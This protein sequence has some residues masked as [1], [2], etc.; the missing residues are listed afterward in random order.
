M[1][2]T[3][4]V[5][6]MK[7]WLMLVSNQRVPS[8]RAVAQLLESLSEQ[9]RLEITSLPGKERVGSE[10]PAVCS[11]SMLIFCLENNIRTNDWWLW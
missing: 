1:A 5:S 11:V 3:K 4:D 9:E 2:A 10:R 8:L 7:K 6:I